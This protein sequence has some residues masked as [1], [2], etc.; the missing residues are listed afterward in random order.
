MIISNILTIVMTESYVFNS[1]TPTCSLDWALTN[2]LDW[3]FSWVDYCRRRWRDE[4][5]FLQ[6]C[7]SN[8]NAKEK[9]WNREFK[10]LYVLLSSFSLISPSRSDVLSLQWSVSRPLSHLLHVR[11]E[12]LTDPVLIAF[13]HISPDWLTTFQH[14]PS[15]KIVGDT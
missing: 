1:N 4:T 9:T 15:I 5:T 13:H 10:L 3:L 12:V 11:H 2:R 14:E 6:E 7:Q 8:L